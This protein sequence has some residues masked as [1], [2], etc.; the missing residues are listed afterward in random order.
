MNKKQILPRIVRCIV[1]RDD[2]I[3]SRE[4]TSSF[5]S[6]AG[7]PKKERR[8]ILPP[9]NGRSNTAYNVTSTEVCQ[10]CAS[11]NTFR[12]STGFAR[13]PAHPRQTRSAHR[14]NY[15]GIL[16]QINRKC[17]RTVTPNINY[18]DAENLSRCEGGSDPLSCSQAVFLQLRVFL[19]QHAV[20]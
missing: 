18:L 19:R 16:T 10:T 12:S 8:I 20:D 14:I 1:R 7:N 15:A 9:E 13:K 3:F 6:P 17:G 2:G 4:T 11:R 5:I